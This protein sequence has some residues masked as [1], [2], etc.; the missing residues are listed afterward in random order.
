MGALTPPPPPP[1]LRDY[2]DIEFSWITDL[3]PSKLLG[4]VLTQSLPPSFEPD[5]S[6][7]VPDFTISV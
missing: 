7:I 3:Y 2:K 6:L 4:C 5:V 1:M